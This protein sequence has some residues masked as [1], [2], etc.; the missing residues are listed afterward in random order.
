MEGPIHY[1]ETG[2][3]QLNDII[4]A[5]KS[6]SLKCLILINEFIFKALSDQNKRAVSPFYQ[7]TRFICENIITGL[8]EDVNQL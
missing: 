8:I 5:V 7:S 1:V 4:A 2:F 6:N 3:N